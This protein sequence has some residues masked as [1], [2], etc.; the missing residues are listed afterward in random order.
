MRAGFFGPAL[1]DVAPTAV[2]FTSDCYLIGL[3]I[4]PLIFLSH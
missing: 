1:S 4:G 3:S 2:P